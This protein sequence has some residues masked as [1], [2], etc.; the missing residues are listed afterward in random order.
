MQVSRGGV[1]TA[2]Y[3]PV[4][5]LF[6][7]AG[8]F[9]AA[10][11]AFRYEVA[12]FLPLLPLL[13]LWKAEGR[14]LRL[15]L[16]CAGLLCG[17]LWS[18]SYDA[19]FR[20]PAR[21]M[22]GQTLTLSAE[23][24][25]WPDSTSYGGAVTVRIAP[26]SGPSFL[27]RLY[28]DGALTN[29]SPGDRVTCLAACRGSD[30]A[31]GKRTGEFTAKGIYLLAYARGTVL[32]RP[33]EG[34]SPR[35]WPAYWG[36]TLR[37]QVS[38]TFPEDTAGLITALLTGDKSG[39]SENRYSDLQR[40]GL[41]HAAAVSGLHMGVLVWLAMGLSGGHRKRAA[42]LAIPLMTTYALAVG[43]TPSVVRAV[44]MN[45]LLLLGPLLGR[46][47]DPPT[48]LSFA[49]FLLLLANPYAAQSIS[50]QLS[51]ASVA[52]I[53]LFS[54]SIRRRLTG[55]AR[56]KIEKGRFERLTGRLV[57]LGAASLATTLG[58]MAFT[59]P[60][61]AVYFG[62]I[63][64]IAPLSNLLCL[65][66]VEL[67]FL[68]GLGEVLAGL[69]IPPLG[70][71]L[72]Q[73]VSL[74]A[75]PLLELIHTLAGI[76]FAAVTLDSVYLSAWLG[77]VYLLWLLFLAFRGRRPIVPL[78]CSAIA[79]CCALVL[80]CMTYQ[81][82]NLTV[83]VLNV[84]QGESVV[85]RAGDRTALLDCGGNTG[86]NAGDICADYLRSRGESRVDLLILTHFHADHAN[87]VLELLERMEVD[88]LAIPDVEADAPLR[89][90]LLAAAAEKGTQVQF[91]RRD[92]NW[93]F[94]TAELTL[95]APLGAGEA[96]EEGLSLLCETEHFSALMTGDMGEDIEAR[97]VKYGHLPS[98]DLLLA[99]HHGAKSATSALL[100]DAVTPRLAAISVGRNSYG[101]PSPETLLRLSEAGVDIYRTDLQGNITITVGP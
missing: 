72:G 99:G 9:I 40:A 22:E 76:P 24:A 11:F 53:L 31:N 56:G 65:P 90:E 82:G 96:N 2:P 10:V 50:L 59:V 41:A 87:G 44:L 23:V 80:T 45:T 78:C 89:L 21:A 37:K 12:V 70:P 88:V 93:S 75:R 68:G 8:S 74:V 26:E 20:A 64:L 101:H 13:A 73:A 27:A 7:A 51:F 71:I 6:T 46:E 100:L 29:L 91:I 77:F 5:K 3:G 35:Y 15:G 47:A 83:T 39:L 98:V 4:R 33:A 42:L 19:W 58:A 28:G 97:L 25:D 81:M 67:V 95:Y 63:S 55:T 34:L 30:L 54:G 52:G 57:R 85:L 86:K 94:G 18:V 66:V 92:E 84:G 48:S 79:L 49:L 38:E 16:V 1:S 36:Q 14:R 43:G 61:A 62:G 60:L 69:F 32:V 17:V